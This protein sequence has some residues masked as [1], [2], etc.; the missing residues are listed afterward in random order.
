MDAQ[1]VFTLNDTERHELSALADLLAGTEPGKI[2]EESWM[3]AGR[4]R[5]ASIPARLAA[6]VRQFRH[7]SGVDGALLI[8]NL[9]VAEGLPPT[10]AVLGSVEREATNPASV[11]T[12]VSLQLGE[13]I[14]FRN[15]KSGA[16]VQNVVPV[17]GQE[18]AQ[19]NAGSKRLGMHVENTFHPNRPDYVALFCL[20]ADHDREAE[21]QITSVRRAVELVSDV[22]R[23][24]LQQPRFV[25]APPSSFPS[26]GGEPEP[27]ALLVGDVD[28]PDVRADFISTVPLD[29]EAAAAKDRLEQAFAEVVESLKL[30]PGDL[31]IVDNRLA[32]HGRSFF[33]PRYDGQDRWL[34]RTFIQLDGRRSR[35]VR[36]GN[37]SVLD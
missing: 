26:L 18:A 22:D 30:E 7:D 14:A 32:L 3:S 15:E 6:R 13:I 34:H 5:S 9:P 1:S 17:P 8:R 20:R 16:L 33:K 23:K 12:L 27:H 29:E 19:N 11:I 21:L 4:D 35:A 24:V 10:P 36:Q 37:G 28:D 2:D 31:A 25:T